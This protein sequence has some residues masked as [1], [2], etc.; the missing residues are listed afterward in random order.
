MLNDGTAG[1]TSTDGIAA[2]TV[3]YR[4]TRRAVI[5]AAAVQTGNRNTLDATG[6][7]TMLQLFT[8]RTGDHARGSNLPHGIYAHALLFMHKKKHPLI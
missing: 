8:D 3:K 6:A 4:F 2:L 7:E 1:H 5:G